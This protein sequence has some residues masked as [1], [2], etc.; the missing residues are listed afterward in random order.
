M[1]KRLSLLVCVLAVLVISTPGILAQHTI[2]YKLNINN[3]A[4]NVYVPGLGEILPSG[5]GPL[6]SYSTPPHFYIASYLSNQLSG[7]VASEGR[8]LY[9][10]KGPGNHTI[11]I[12]QDLQNSRMLLTFTQGD[13]QNIERVI[14]LIEAGKFLMELSPAF[15]FPSAGALY[16]VT[17]MLRYPGIDLTGD[18]TTGKGSMSLAIENKG[19]VGDNLTINIEK[20]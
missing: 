9:Y 11:G 8:N 7:L 6:T 13:W 17:I 12:Q 20:S 19:L 14:L 5:L 3:T 10:G 15:G 2:E 4:H 18:L 1:Q 16:P